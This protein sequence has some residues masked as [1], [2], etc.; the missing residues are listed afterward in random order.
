MQLR[1][2]VEEDRALLKLGKFLSRH[3]DILPK[4]RPAQDDEDEIVSLRLE[5]AKVSTAL[6]H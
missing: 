6:T 2:A 3:A 5:D 1:G 4:R